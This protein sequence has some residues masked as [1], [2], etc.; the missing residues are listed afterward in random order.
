VDEGTAFALD[1]TG[2]TDVLSDTLTYGWDL[3]YDGATFV[4]D[5]VGA[6]PSI[7]YPNGPDSFTIA[8]RVIDD[9]G[10]VSAVDTL[11][12]TVQNVAPTVDV[13]DQAGSEGVP[14]A[15]SAAIT[16][17]GPQDTF[18]YLWA[19]GDGVTSTLAAPSHTYQD[20]GPF[21]VS[22]TVY[23]SDGAGPAVD[24]ATANVAN[25][26]PV[27]Y[28][29]LDQV[30]AQMEL[31]NL[32]GSG[33]TDVAGDTLS[34]AWDFDYDGVTFDEDATGATTSTSYGTMGTYTVALRVRD[35]DGGEGLDTLSVKVKEVAVTADAGGDQTVEEEQTVN[36][37][38]SGTGLGTLSYAWDFDYD[39]SNFDVDATGPTASTS[40]PDGPIAPTVA[41]RVTDGDG[42]S[43]IDT[44]LITVLNADP[45][46]DAGGPLAAEGGEVVTFTVT[47]ADAAADTHTVEWDL[48][49]DGVYE[50]VGQTAQRTFAT[51]G[52]FQVGVRVT[53]D[54]GGVATAVVQV[55]IGGYK[56]YLPLVD[57][58]A[59]G[60]GQ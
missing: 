1:G 45:V 59:G 27:A 40:Y 13:G 60:A 3:S 14:I 10:G 17:P 26:A 25:V 50:T 7:S 55:V 37:S 15:F 53:D 16:D 22:V 12:V 47:I 8:L 48:D 30:V 39:G 5:T 58:P 57:R 34:Y 28:A 11:L 6:T 56:I 2:S 4:T 18:T 29:G 52:E 31:V 19:F 35:D 42:D 33:S 51:P 21:T 23:D 32:D 36:L 20:D 44:A 9:D 49:D 43:V 38:G 41:L 24:Q 46:I 54:D